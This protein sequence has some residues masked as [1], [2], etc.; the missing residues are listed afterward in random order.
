[1]KLILST[2]VTSRKKESIEV[3]HV[4]KT[5]NWR[6]YT[7]GEAEQVNDHDDAR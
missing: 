1:M 7:K 6:N 5:S 4:M 3:R 2:C